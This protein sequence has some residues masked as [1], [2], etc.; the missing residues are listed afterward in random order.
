MCCVLC[1]HTLIIPNAA[2]VGLS[3][4]SAFNLARLPYSNYFDDLWAP[5]WIVY[6]PASRWILKIIVGSTALE[7]AQPPLYIVYPALHLG[8]LTITVTLIIMFAKCPFRLKGW[9]SRPPCVSSSKPARVVIYWKLSANCQ[10]RIDIAC[11]RPLVCSRRAVFLFL[12]SYPLR[13]LRDYNL[14]HLPTTELLT[15]YL[16]YFRTGL[17]SL[18]CLTISHCQRKWRRR[19][20][21]VRMPTSFG[22]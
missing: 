14:L 20:S 16:V 6:L 1:A 15:F 13:R 4:L 11:C 22:R 10:I 5:K 7:L 21:F 8:R 2:C 18:S 17:S 19:D 9:F 12:F 3:V